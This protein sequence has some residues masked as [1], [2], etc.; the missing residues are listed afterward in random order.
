[1]EGKVRFY[2]YGAPESTG[3]KYNG[4]D[5]RGEVLLLSRN[6]RVVGEDIWSWGG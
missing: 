5:I 3:D 4:V 2:H 6:V 1:L